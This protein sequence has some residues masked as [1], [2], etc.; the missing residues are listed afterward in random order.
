MIE[1]LVTIDRAKLDRLVASRD[2]WKKTAKT[3]RRAFYLSREFSDGWYRAYRRAMGFSDE[4][5][6]LVDGARPV[7]GAIYGI[8]RWLKRLVYGE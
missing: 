6:I 3:Y 4:P 1:D 5:H 7:M 8:G 2:S